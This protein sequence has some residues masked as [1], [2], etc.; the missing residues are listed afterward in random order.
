V[1]DEVEDEERALKLFDNAAD[2]EAVRREIGALR[3]DPSSERRRGLLGGQDQC[4]RLVP[5][6][7][8]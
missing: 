2:Y 6:R 5:H 3:K 1:R 4:R 8:K 7:R